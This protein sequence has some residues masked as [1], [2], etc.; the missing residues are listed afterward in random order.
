MFVGKHLLLP[1]QFGRNLL[2]DASHMDPYRGGQMARAQG[3]EQACD[4]H[5][6]LL[7]Q[8]KMTL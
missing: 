5:W 1:L 8:V 6:S 3:A 4:H 2:E 7:L